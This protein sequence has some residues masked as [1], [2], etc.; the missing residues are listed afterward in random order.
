MLREEGEVRRPGLRTED[1]VHHAEDQRGPAAQFGPLFGGKEGGKGGSR[2]VEEN[3]AG[4]R[5]EERVG[6][7]E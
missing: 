7:C 6:L 1:L 4:N 3:G 2:G 5:E